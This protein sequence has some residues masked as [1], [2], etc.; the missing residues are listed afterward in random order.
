[1]SLSWDADCKGACH[2]HMCFSQVF[3]LSGL[4][5][6]ADDS[7]PRLT[8]NTVFPTSDV[9]LICPD[10]I[11]VYSQKGSPHRALGPGNVSHR[12]SATAALGF[13]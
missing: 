10:K 1:M 2:A 6:M 5:L 12:A 4:F 7:I 9:L 11:A 3:K 8:V 13:R